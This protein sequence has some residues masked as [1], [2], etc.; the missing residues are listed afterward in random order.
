MLKQKKTK[1]VTDV[2]LVIF[3]SYQ[4][5][6]GIS[7]TRALRVNSIR[8]KVFAVYEDREPPGYTI[9][10]WAAREHRP[11][12]V[13]FVP[14]C[15]RAPRETA[16]TRRPQERINPDLYRTDW[17]ISSHRPWNIIVGSKKITRDGRP[18]IISVEWLCRW[19]R[20]DYCVTAKLITARVPNGFWRRKNR[21]M[22]TRRY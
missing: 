4:F 12:F 6:S 19:P 8:K 22:I 13:I 18:T 7:R 21:V 15:V 9:A 17:T 11:R 5:P 16:D 10:Q 20:A 3:F 14:P 2:K 1:I